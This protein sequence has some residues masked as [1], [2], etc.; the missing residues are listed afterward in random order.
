MAQTGDVALALWPVLVG[1]GVLGAAVVVALAA[2]WARARRRLVR[3]QGQIQALADWRQATESLATRARVVVWQADPALRYTAVSAAAEAVYRR[4][5]AELVGQRALLDLRES[6]H[7]PV[8]ARRLREALDRRDGLSDCENRIVTASGEP[9]WVSTTVVPAWDARGELVGLTGCDIDINGRKRLQEALQA[10]EQRY[11]L[12]TEHAQ[13]IIYTIDPSGRLTYVSPSWTTLLGHAPSEVIGLDFR[14]FVHPEDVPACEALLE[15]TVR[16]RQVQPALT[17]RVFHRDGSVRYHRSVLV[18]SYDGA[19]QLQAVVGNAIDVSTDIQL[20]AD[21]ERLATHDPLTG[22][23]NR[24]LFMEQF[25]REIDRARRSGRPL[26]LL[27]LDIDHFKRANDTHG[28]AAGDRVLE[29]FVRRCQAALRPSDVLGRLGGEEFAAMLPDASTAQVLA[30]AERLR[31]EIESPTFAI[32]GDGTLEVTVSIG[33][34]VALPEEDGDALLA[35]ADAALYSAK[36]QGRNRVVMDGVEP[37]SSPVP[38][39]A[40]GPGIDF[41]SLPRH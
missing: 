23:A 29:E 24:R 26:G 34:I 38:A 1:G 22:A 32:P 19:G 15:A 40:A 10:A 8:F 14:P 4:A 13:S 37:A 25:H 36:R 30:I 11:R 28:H 2:L 12:L 39:D 6:S 33:G 3:A 35:R 7:R 27:M 18:P 21:L 31:R 9:L 20:R 5:P 17:Y 41:P 16:L